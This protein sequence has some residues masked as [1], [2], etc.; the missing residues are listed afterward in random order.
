[1]DPMPIE[2][3]SILLAIVFFSILAY[4]SWI[5]YHEHLH[6]HRKSNETNPRHFASAN[7][8]FRP[9]RPRKRRD[10]ESSTS[11]R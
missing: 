5:K 2:V 1:M 4:V 10:S 7:K 9:S 6:H 8:I 3:F 11:G